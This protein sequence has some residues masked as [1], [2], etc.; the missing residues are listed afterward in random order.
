MHN[1]HEVYFDTLNGLLTFPITPSEM[2]I[3][4]GSKNET[5]TLISEGDINILKSPGLVE[6][7]FEARFPMRKYP[8]SRTPLP[9][10]SYVTLLNT[11][12]TEKQP[13]RFIVARMSPNGQRTWDTNLLMALENY[14]IEESV[15]EGDDVL[16]SFELKQYKE[17]G[18][19]KVNWDKDGLLSSSGSSGSTSTSSTNRD[20]G[21]GRS[22]PAKHT[23]VDGDRLWNIAKM[24]YGSGTKHPTIYRANKSAIEADAKKHGMASSS[25][26]HWIYPGLT[27]TIPKA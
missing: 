24:Y 8:Y 21:N 26:G 17:Y 7:S 25:N 9:L 14:T 22:L 27:L 10:Q 4:V 2:S 6:V 18:I 12:L 16:I 1:G 19:K 15:S 3:K 11:L 5:V 23:V 13:F 20:P